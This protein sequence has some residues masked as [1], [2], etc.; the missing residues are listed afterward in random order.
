MEALIHHFKYFSKG[1]IMPEGSLYTA[2]EAPKG[3]FGIFLAMDREGNKPF[4]CYLRAP[5]FYHL[6]GI[7]ISRNTMP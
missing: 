2:V 3:E 1:T 6:A 7:H 4:R 5:G